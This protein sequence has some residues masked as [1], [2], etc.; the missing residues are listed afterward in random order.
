MIFASVNRKLTR[1]SRREI[2]QFRV[3]FQ[4]GYSGSGYYGTVGNVAG[5]NNAVSA[6]DSLYRY[7]SPHRPAY[8]PGRPITE[9]R[10]SARK[11]RRDIG[12]HGEI[13]IHR[14]ADCTNCGA[15][16]IT[17]IGLRLCRRHQS[18]LRQWQYLVWQVA[19]ITTQSAVSLARQVV[20][21]L[22]RCLAQTAQEQCSLVPPLAYCATTQAS[23]PAA[24]VNHRA[25]LGRA[26]KRS[27]RRGVPPMAVF[28][29]LG[30]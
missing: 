9:I 30:T 1:Q 5:R 28:S 17:T 26:I 27:R 12:Y 16:D 21:W 13:A 3:A 8:S 29:F 22:P 14:G 6:A 23:A 24:K 18:S 10:L 25:R 20:S 15:V 11:N 7:P 4:Q 19:S 2:A